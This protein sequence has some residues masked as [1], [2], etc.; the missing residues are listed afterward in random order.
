MFK[1]LALCVLVVAVACMTTGLKAQE[2]T[3]DVAFLRVGYQWN[4]L[5]PDA[6]NATDIKLNGVAIEGE[7][8]LNLG[9]M[10]LGFSLEYAYLSWTEDK[11]YDYGF[12]SPMVTLKFLAP[13][14]FYIGPGLSLRYLMSSYQPDIYPEPDS[15]VDLWVNGVAGYMAPIAEGIYLDLQARF[16]WNLTKNQFEDSYSKIDKNDDMAFYVGFGSRTRA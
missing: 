16:G 14:G 12:L 5:K 15:E 11:A 4:T 8:N 7:Y 9:G 13:G 6:P 2:M 3:D 1:K 10:L